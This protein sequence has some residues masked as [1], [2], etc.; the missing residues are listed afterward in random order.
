M[1]CAPNFRG[2]SI[3][4]H[5]AS[6]LPHF[7][8]KAVA[9]SFENENNQESNTISLIVW[10]IN[11]LNNY[12]CDCFAVLKIASA[13]ALAACQFEVCY[14]DT[15]GLLKI[16]MLLFEVQ[17]FSHFWCVKTHFP[18]LVWSQASG[19]QKWF[20]SATVGVQN[21]FSS[22]DLVSCALRWE[23][24][25]CMRL[26][27]P[28]EPIQTCFWW[29]CKWRWLHQIPLMGRWRL[30]PQTCFWFQFCSLFQCTSKL[31]T[32]YC[33]NVWITLDFLW[34]E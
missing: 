27:Q 32:I 15:L 2:F 3:K 9:C 26:S 16:C 24:L 6:L 18:L 12:F 23:P 22:W 31:W 8:T 1:Q 4:L 10:H 29:Q 33:E 5:L 21:N 28:H 19:V 34:Y 20:S 7:Q 13:Y 30:T 14:L 17:I 11:F 25:L